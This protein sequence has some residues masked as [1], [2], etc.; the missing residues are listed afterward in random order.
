MDEWAGPEPW[1]LVVVGFFVFASVLCAIIAWAHKGRARRDYLG[2]LRQQL[3]ARADD[4]TEV[5]HS[6]RNAQMDGGD[7][8]REAERAEELYVGECR[9]RAHAAS[10][11]G[12]LAASH[13]RRADGDPHGHCH[14]QRA[15]TADNRVTALPK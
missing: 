2:K 4:A 10:R 3:L 9:T 1:A 5:H 6:R 11:D 7:Q 12:I 14:V 15:Q 13:L 8:G